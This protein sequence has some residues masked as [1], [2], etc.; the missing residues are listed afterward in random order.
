MLFITPDENN[1]MK[2]L[3]NN[4]GIVVKFELMEEQYPTHDINSNEIIVPTTETLLK[5]CVILFYYSVSHTKRIVTVNNDIIYDKNNIKIGG[6]YVTTP[7]SVS[8]FT[9]QYH[10]FYLWNNNDSS[11]SF[12]GKFYNFSYLQNITEKEANNLHQ[13]YNYIHDI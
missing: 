1:Y 3:Y 2:L 8:I 9:H 10:D 6:R 7:S 5:K 12:N 11:K 13:C 4:K